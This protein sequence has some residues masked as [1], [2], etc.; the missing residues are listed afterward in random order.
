MELYYGIVQYFSNKLRM[1]YTIRQFPGPKAYPFIGNSHLFIGDIEDITNQFLEI[2]KKYHSLWRVWLGTKLLVMVDDPKY[3]ENILHST[4]AIEKSEEYD[5]LKIAMGN[6]LF[7]APVSK[8]KGHRKLL[9]EAFQNKNIQSHMNVFLNHSITLMEKLDSLV[10]KDIDVCHYVYRC[11]L[12]IIYDGMLDIQVN[13]LT[14]PDSELAK[15]IECGTH[16]L[17]VRLFK[18]WLHPDIL[19]Y[20]TAIGKKF[21]KCL[22]CMDNVTNNIMKKKEESILENKI[23]R[24]LTE[25]NSEN[26]RVFLDLLFESSHEEEE[27]SKQDIRDEINTMIIA[28]SDTITTTISFVLLMLATFPDIQ[29]E[30]YE[31]LNQMYNSSDPKHVPIL[32]DDIKNMKLLDRVIKETL[33]LFPIGPIIGRKVTKD[34]TVEKNLTIPKGSSL[35]FWV[36]KLHRN[37]K[38]WD[39]PLKFDPNRFLSSNIPS[40][41]FLPFGIG[42]RNCL[43]QTFA[44]LEMKVIIGTILRKF[45]IKIDRSIVIEDIAVKLNI[46][47]KPAKPIVLQF[48][49]RN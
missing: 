4:D 14:N 47:L 46:T 3:I 24:K 6:G 2:S 49:R 36:Y 44:M 15:S 1:Y 10:G 41:S 45:I 18:L 37:K 35:I 9:K 7:S 20:N 19:F 8:W 21:Q 17:A 31:E 12:D 38:Y 28:G 23:N 5:H 42:A 48:E 39:D 32:H 13:T 40:Y 27:Y 30:V 43:G 25:E 11:A 34:I 26:P 22:S 16:I 33:R 29:N